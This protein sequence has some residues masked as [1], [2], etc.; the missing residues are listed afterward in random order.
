MLWQGLSLMGGRW[1]ERGG[2]ASGW[3]VELLLSACR[4]ADELLPPAVDQHPSTDWT[5]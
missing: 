4:H 2:H 1:F 3:D 5:R